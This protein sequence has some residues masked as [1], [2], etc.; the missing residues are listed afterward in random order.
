M[1]CILHHLPDCRD[2]PHHSLEQLLSLPLVWAK[3]LFL[4]CSHDQ[5]LLDKVMEMTAGP[6]VEE[7]VQSTTGSE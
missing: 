6:E 2:S 7:L 3:H 5:D 4:G 1:E